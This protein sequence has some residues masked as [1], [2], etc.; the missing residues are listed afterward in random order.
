MSEAN[1]LGLMLDKARRYIDT[2]ELLRRNSDFDSAASRLCYAMFYCADALLWQRGLK[3]SRHSAVIAA[4]GQHFA[5][6]GLLPSQLHHWF[7]D[8]FDRR[9]EGD[10]QFEPVVTEETVVE[11][12]RRAAE[13]LNQTEAFLRS[14]PSA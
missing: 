13:F 4:F 1:T 8:A 14:Q 5:K 10:Y 2:A 11:L 6:T 7:Q 9:N 3:F 12:Q